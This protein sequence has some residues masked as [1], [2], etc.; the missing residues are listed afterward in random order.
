MRGRERVMLAALV[1]AAAASALALAKLMELRVEGGDVYPAYSSHRAD[2][3]GTSA[4]LDTLAAVPGVSADRNHRAPGRLEAGAGRTMVVLGAEPRWLTAMPDRDANGLERFVSGGGRLVVA[5][6]PGPT[7]WWAST[8]Q[9]RATTKPASRAA[10]EGG[11]DGNDGDGDEKSMVAMTDLAKRWELGWS[12]HEVKPGSQRAAPADDDANMGPGVM[13]RGRLY[14]DDLGPQWRTV[15]EFR[16]R[17][18]IVERRLGTGTIVAAADTFFAS[19]EAMRSQ[20]RPMLLAWLVGPSRQVTFDETHLGV[21]E[22]PG[23]MVLARRY[24]LSWALAALGLVA[25]LFVWRSATSLAPRACVRREELGVR[26]AGRDSSAGLVNLL[27]R[28]VPAGRLL[29]TCFEE[30]AKRLPAGRRDVAAKAARMRQIVEREES[31]PRRK[32][33]PVRAYREMAAV[34]AERG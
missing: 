5:L 6:A 11:N 27:H 18:A 8:R 32:R 12:E 33:D 14:F 21:Q 25:G 16:G 26:V 34:L 30:W 31:L 20:R 9:W 22:E 10:S 3:K 4:L 28:A 29:R 24:G 15:W 23:V 1:A 19:N 17:P 7:R 13:W 2:P